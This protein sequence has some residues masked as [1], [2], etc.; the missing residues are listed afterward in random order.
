M[1]LFP[2]LL[3]HILKYIKNNQLIICVEAP[4]ELKLDVKVDGHF[5][6]LLIYVLGVLGNGDKLLN[7]NDLSKSLLLFFFPPVCFS[8]A[9]DVRRA[10]D[11][12]EVVGCDGPA[13]CCC[14]AMLPT[15]LSHA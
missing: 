3:L 7:R 4:N 13:A 15:P 11:F 2:R 1:E 6:S 5:E 12:A 8:G 14:R 9:V 10:C